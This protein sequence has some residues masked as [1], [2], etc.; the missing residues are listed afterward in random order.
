MKTH[1]MGVSVAML[2]VGALFASNPAFASCEG[3]C[4]QEYANCVADPNDGIPAPACQVLYNQCLRQCDLL[5]V[6]EESLSADMKQS[7]KARCEWRPSH[8]QSQPLRIELA[9]R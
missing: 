8:H 4:F 6:P 2:A 3:D 5:V 7:G 1:V 9:S